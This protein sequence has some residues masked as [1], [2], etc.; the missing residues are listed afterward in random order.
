MAGRKGGMI[1]NHMEE[2][3]ALR[4]IIEPHYNCAQSLLVPFADVTGIPKEKAMELGFLFGGGMHH[5]SV[6]GT[7]TAAYM[8][9]GMAGCSKEDAAGLLR[10]FKEK[11]GSEL[12]RDLLAASAKAGLVKKQHCDGLVFE[13]CEYLDDFF[14][15]RERAA[16]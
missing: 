7:L 11:H 10:T 5:G 12:C 9:L 14:T 4:A 15:E 16:G 8:I 13:V 1:M 3:R 6:C 2:V